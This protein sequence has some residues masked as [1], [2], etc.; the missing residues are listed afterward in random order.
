MAVAGGAVGLGNFLRFPGQVAQYGG[1][2]F[3]IAYFVSLL[4]IGLPI[5]WAEWTMGRFGGKKGFSAAPGVFNLIWGRPFAKYFGIL[6]IIIPLGIFTYYVYIQ[7][8]CLGYAVN[9]LFGMFDFKNIAEAQTFWENFVGVHEDG[10]ALGFGMQKVG[11]YI[12]IA[13][14][15]D[16]FLIFRGVSK[17]IEFFTKRAI[18]LLIFIA[19]IITIRVLT[20]GTPDPQTPENNINNGLG[21]MWN[22]NKAVLQSWNTEQSTWEN[23]YQV[24]GEIAQKDAQTLVATSPDSYKIEETT[25]WD[26]LKRPRLWLAAASQI[27]LSL[28][29]GAGLIIVYASYMKKDDDV[30]LSN[31]SST[32]ANEFSEV[33]LGGLMTIPAGFAFLGAASVQNAGTFGLGFNVLPMVFAKM[34]LGQLFGFLFFFLLFLAS[35]SATLA[36]LQPGKAFL[37]EV[38]GWGHKRTIALLFAITASSACIVFWYT[39]GLKALDT[40]DFW[41]TFLMFVMVTFE[42]ITFSW[43]M[44]A[45][46]GMKEANRGS[47]FPI[48]KFFYPIF[49]YICPI[50]LLTVF[51]LWVLLD[52]LGLGGQGID[53]RIVDLF[54]GNGQKPDPVAWL[55]VG[56]ILFLA[57]LYIFIVAKS[58]RYK[59]GFFGMK[60]G[61]K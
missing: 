10:S 58:K 13:F 61:K 53:H 49:K 7:A 24:I 38:L 16:F 33:A 28:C 45:K 21:F 20:L 50:F 31:V 37:Q 35:V 40:F 41:I 2:A 60:W 26:Q 6:A 18:P 1:G 15:I 52:A 14:I 25:I 46:K 4:I 9:Y 12:L 8:W 55:C 30:V 23:Q 39:K 57:T 29:L 44:G 5:G 56:N 43:G 32:S 54:G 22:P 48:P 17:G 19:I 51:V 47:A 59:K 42:I 36:M 11:G 3:M 34:P 27:F